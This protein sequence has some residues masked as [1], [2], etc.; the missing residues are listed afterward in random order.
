MMRICFI[1][2]SFVNG[3]GD[4]ECLGWAGRV[5][6]D[7]RRRGFDVTCYNLGIRRDSTADIAGRWRREVA[8]RLPDDVD[9]K[10]IFSFGINDCTGPEARISHTDA[11]ANAATILRNAAAW[12]PTLMVG[13]PPVADCSV[14]DS[15]VQ[16]LSCDLA[17]LCGSL[18]VPYLDL[19]SA[20]AAD[21]AWRDAA[22]AG[23]GIH[24]SAEGY[25]KMAALVTDWPA[26]RAWFYSPDATEPN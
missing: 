25:A 19:H 12:K 9:G 10:L 8:L 14:T 3:T 2:D 4:D 7:A 11:L 22:L 16:A 13:P 21:I 1:G 17:I 23:D 24:P 20:L 18:G 26:W 6:A 15:R 5:C